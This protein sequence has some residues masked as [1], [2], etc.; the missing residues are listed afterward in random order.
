MGLWIVCFE[1]VIFGG[2]VDWLCNII[3]FVVFGILVE[4]VLIV[5]DLECVL[6]LLGFVCFFGKVLVL[7]VLIVMGVDEDIVWGVICISLGWNMIRDDID[8]VFEIWLRIVDCFNLEVC[9]KV[10]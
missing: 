8:C 3:C 4:M 6:V 9:I 1:I 2:L 10:V 5:F 7:Y